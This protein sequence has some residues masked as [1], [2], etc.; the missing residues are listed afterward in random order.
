MID[1]LPLSPAAVSVV[2]T[3]ILNQILATVLITYKYLPLIAEPQHLSLAAEPGTAELWTEVL[4]HSLAAE[5]V[6]ETH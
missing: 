6:D 3:G 1:S 4:L 2:N 5:P